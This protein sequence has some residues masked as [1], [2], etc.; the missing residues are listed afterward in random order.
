MITTVTKKVLQKQ[1]AATTVGWLIFWT[2]SN[3]TVTWNCA[4][5]KA[6]KKYAPV[7]L[8]GTVCHENSFHAHKYDGAKL[9]P[10]EAEHGHLP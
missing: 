2:L 3:V 10:Q 8:L 7:R 1:N 5:F 6:K 4:E 9:D